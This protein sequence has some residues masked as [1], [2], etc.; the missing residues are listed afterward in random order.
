VPVLVIGA[1][2]AGLACARGL[3]A[4]GLDVLVVDKARGPGGRLS[5][6]RSAEHAFDHGAQYFRL[7]DA[8]LT[9]LLASLLAAGVVAPWRTRLVTLRDGISHPRDDGATRYVGVPGMSAVARALGATLPVTYGSAV[10]SLTRGPDGWTATTDAG[11]ALPGRFAAVVVAT[12]AAQAVPLL[13]AAP[14][15]A[16]RV[17]AVE[18]DPCW[19]T[20]V[21]F[22]APLALAFDAAF[23]EGGPLGWIARNSSKPERPP[24][25]AWVLHASPQWSSLHMEDTPDVVAAALLAAFAAATAHPHPAPTHVAAH[26]WRYARTRTPLGAAFLY[27]TQLGLAVCGDWCLGATVECALLSGAALAEAMR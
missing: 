15:L 2:L 26:R 5:T 18:V 20:M 12:P 3:A 25:D 24:G 27:D 23:V 19:A 11:A 14:A 9:S 13:A 16:R 1:G 7:R 8:S 10:T 17:A 4:P 22:A 21:A 6:R